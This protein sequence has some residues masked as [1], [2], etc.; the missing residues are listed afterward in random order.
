MQ[1]PITFT[2]SNNSL[3]SFKTDL[4]FCGLYEGEKINKDLGNTVSDAIK[5]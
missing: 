3:S 2:N 5:V 1:N 4:I